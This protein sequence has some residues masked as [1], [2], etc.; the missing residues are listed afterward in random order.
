VA[1]KFDAE[2]I[3]GFTFLEFCAGINGYQG[4][5]FDR[6][7]ARRLYF[8]HQSRAAGGAVDLVDD[9]H[10]P[11]RKIINSGDRGEVIVSEF[12]PQCG[13]KFN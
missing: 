13:S 4:R 10:F 12:I 8:E 3:P 9:F 6:I 1:G 5:D 11:F 2:Q 7:C